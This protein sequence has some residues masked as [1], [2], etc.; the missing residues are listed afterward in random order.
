MDFE[1][2]CRQ[3]EIACKAGA[4]GFLGGRA[5]WQEAMNIDNE[6]KRV[7]YLSTVAVDRLKKLIGIASRYGVP[8]YRKFGGSV[9]ELAK[10]SESWYKEY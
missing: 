6:Q 10:I 1:L 3:V 7:G 4:S 2:F 5:I 9:G 8:W